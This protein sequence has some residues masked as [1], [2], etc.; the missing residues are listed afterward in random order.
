MDGCKLGAIAGH[1][2]LDFGGGNNSAG[3]DWI[4]RDGAL[5]APAALEPIGPPN[6]VTDQDYRFSSADPG[7]GH[8]RVA[9]MIGAKRYSC[10]LWYAKRADFSQR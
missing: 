5:A 10:E 9:S 7:L 3:L 1:Y 4:L 6:V 8:K 2:V